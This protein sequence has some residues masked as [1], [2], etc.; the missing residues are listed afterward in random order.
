MVGSNYPF[1]VC[2]I[3]QLASEI[4]APTHSKTNGGS[5]S[6]VDELTIEVVPP[7]KDLD[8]TNT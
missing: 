6:N 7:P 3:G 2:R 8:Y 5:N 1:T 4:C